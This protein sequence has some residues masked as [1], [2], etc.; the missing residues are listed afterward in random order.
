MK[1]KPWTKKERNNFSV[2]IWLCMEVKKSKLVSEVEQ[3]IKMLKKENERLKKLLQAGVNLLDR[4]KQENAHWKS[5]YHDL[6]SYC[7]IK[8]RD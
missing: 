8:Y 3:E 7:Q 5:I 6:D 2:S 1:N 4:Y